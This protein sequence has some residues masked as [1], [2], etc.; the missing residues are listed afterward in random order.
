MANPERQRVGPAPVVSCRGAQPLARR[1]RRP[2][3]RD[4]AN[5][6]PR[7]ETPSAPAVS[8]EARA[9]A[10]A[11]AR[12]VA[13]HKTEQVVVLNLTGLSTI[14][15]FFVI[16]T[17]TS[18]RQMRAALDAIADYARGLHRR[19]FTSPE[20]A[21][22]TWLLADYVDVVIHI[23]DEQHREFYDLEGLWGDAP[24]VAWEPDAATIS[25]D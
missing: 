13:D 25:G 24:R 5:A 16:G 8:E 6:E 18:D 23:F 3:N 2:Y 10:V 12:I 20:R 1:R 17:G 4:M 7:A 9:F 15:D 22:T 19:P 11:A 21:G 14:A